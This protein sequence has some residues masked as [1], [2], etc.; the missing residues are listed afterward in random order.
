MKRSRVLSFLL[1]LCV[2]LSWGYMTGWIPQSRAS[3]TLHMGLGSF[4]KKRL[5]GHGGENEN[6]DK[7]DT[8]LP[9]KNQSAGPEQSTPPPQ[10]MTREDVSSSRPPMQAKG[11][12]SSAPRV[13]YPAVETAQDRINRVKQGKM[14][15]EEKQKFLASTLKNVASVNPLPKTGNLHPVR[16]PLL[17]DSALIKR[18][19]RSSAT[20][21]PK[22][23]ML[24]EVVTGR[25]D[26]KS[27]D[28]WTSSN[29]KKKEYFDMVTNPN[30]FNTFNTQGSVVPAP[31][32]P[33]PPTPLAT[34]DYSYNSVNSPSLIPWETTIPS[35]SGSTA[36]APVPVPPPTFDPNDSNHLGARLEAAAMAEEQRQREA[37]RAVE[38][39]RE[40]E[41]RRQEELIRAREEEMAMR[42]A[43]ILRRKEEALELARQQEARRRE[44]DRLRQEQMM[45]A[46]E[47]YWAKK[48][49]A[50]RQRKLE[51]LSQQDQV[52]EQTRM[53]ENDSQQE[54][55]WVQNSESEDQGQVPVAYEVSGR[56]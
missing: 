45:K 38:I 24:R 16:Q 54:Q 55:P 19:S 32:P 40:E 41:M 53:D 15:D 36:A 11:V 21:F 47:E 44:E 39:Q 49:K 52:V 18:G 51:K 56:S 29:K 31:S 27:A 48:L 14:T 13:P 25:R 8:S 30:R 23:S 7:P 50:E 34:P 9:N 46:Q 2:P 22:D 1:S 6:N 3:T 26:Q 37:R 4:V 42:E 20:P 12:V 10:Q 35:S 5:L 17:E 33:L 43:E 28:D